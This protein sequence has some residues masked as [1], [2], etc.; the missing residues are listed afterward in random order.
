MSGRSSVGV[1][2]V[3]APAQALGGGVD[4]RGRASARSGASA[5]APSAGGAFSIGDAPGP[6]RL[7]GVAGPDDEQVGDG[8]QGRVVLDRLVRR[9][10]LARRR[11]CRAC[12]PR[13]TPS[14]RER[15]Q[16][17]RRAHVVGE[18]E[19]RGAVRDEAAVQARGRSRPR[20]WRARGR[21]SGGCVPRS[22]RRR[23][24]CP[25]RRPGLRRRRL[26][27]ARPLSQVKVDGFR[28]AEPPTSSGSRGASACI[29][30][31][32][33]FRVAS[34]FGVGGERRQLGVPARGQLAR[35]DGAR[36]SRGQVRE[37]L[38]VGLRGALSSRAR[39]ARR[40]RPRSGSGPRPRAGSG[41]PARRGQPRFSLAARTS[42][43]PSGEPWAS[44]VSC[45]CGAP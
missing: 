35:R 8:A 2:H 10:V 4:G 33:A 11:C 22:P 20:P 40:A 30:A 31:S 17:D 18:D 25:A 38:R 6:D 26:E 7:V 44:K 24:P 36:S 9:A 41:T 37:G 39:P 28:S 13:S 21:R 15:R 29:T 45:L 19:E 43:G 14:S 23:R 3:G 27:V 34:P 42:S 16:P 5:P 12:R 32:D 1:Q